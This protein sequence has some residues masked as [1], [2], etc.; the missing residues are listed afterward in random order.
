MDIKG[1][2]QLQVEWYN[3]NPT[4]LMDLPTAALHLISIRM[5]FDVEFTLSL[6]T[7]I[8]RL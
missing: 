6:V 2:H 1:G 7:I 3:I 4:N 8:E 5:H